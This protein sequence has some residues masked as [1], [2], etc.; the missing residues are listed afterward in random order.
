[1]SAQLQTPILISTL[2]F[3]GTLL[4]PEEPQRRTLGIFRHSE[5]QQQYNDAE[6]MRHVAAKS[7]D[8]HCDTI[9]SYTISPLIN[10]SYLSVLSSSCDKQ[11]VRYCML[12]QS[13]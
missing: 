8:I 12:R 5:S 6:Q 3:L 2:L 7:K 1:M 10:E 9:P 4:S 11:V 13:E